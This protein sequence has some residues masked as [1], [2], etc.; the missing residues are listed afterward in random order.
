MEVEERRR[1]DHVASPDNWYA[2]STASDGHEV[3]GVIGVSDNGEHDHHLRRT[4]AER[5]LS[6]RADST[7]RN[8]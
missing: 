4:R 2:E 5:R 6:V 8:C 3:A 7:R 1:A